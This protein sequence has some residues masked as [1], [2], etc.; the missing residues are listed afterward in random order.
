MGVRP[1]RLGLANSVM[2]LNNRSNLSAFESSQA[3]K[4]AGLELKKDMKMRPRKIV[5]DIPV[6]V[7]CENILN[8]IVKQNIP[9]AKSDDSKVYSDRKMRRQ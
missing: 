9:E 2:L 5:H 6:E 3:L 1:V 7:T 4:E 8:C